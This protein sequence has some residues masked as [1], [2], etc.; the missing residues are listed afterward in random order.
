M[1]TTIVSPDGWE[2]SSRSGGSAFGAGNCIEVKIVT[3]R[4]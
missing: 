4:A 2:K 3:D 1:S